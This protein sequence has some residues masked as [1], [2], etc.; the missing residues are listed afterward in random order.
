M[1]AENL[2]DVIIYSSPD[3]PKKRNR[4]FAFL[5][6]TTHKDASV[7]K[8][9]IQLMSALGSTEVYQ[10]ITVSGPVL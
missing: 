10:R 3:D 7:A 4:G 9:W 8:R 2:Q 6:Y 5:E 1:F